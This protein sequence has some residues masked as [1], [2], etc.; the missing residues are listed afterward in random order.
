MN[1]DEFDLPPIEETLSA[2][3]RE[4]W[5]DDPRPSKEQPQ[6]IS[7]ARIEQSLLVVA[8][9]LALPRKPFLKCALVCAL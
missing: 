1:R 8:N 9:T 4:I 3:H 7:F 5:E 6:R 2:K